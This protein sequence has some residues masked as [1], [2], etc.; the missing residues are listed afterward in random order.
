MTRR[1]LEASL[2][3]RVALTAMIASALFG[4]DWDWNIPKGFPRPVVPS[5]NPMS[6]VKVELGYLF[7][8]KRLCVN[9]KESCGSCHKQELAFTDTPL[10]IVGFTSI[11]RRTR[12][13][14]GF[15]RRGCGM[16]P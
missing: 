5:D 10:R 7:Y 4:A 11:R 16:S 12:I 13:S 8:D 2:F 1:R 15:A 9:G 6:A 3:K 14:G